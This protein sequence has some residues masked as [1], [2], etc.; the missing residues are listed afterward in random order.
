MDEMNSDES[1]TQR[2]FQAIDATLGHG[3]RGLTSPD[4]TLIRNSFINELKS[5]EPIDYPAMVEAVLGNYEPVDPSVKADRIKNIKTR[6]LTQPEKKKFDSQFNAVGS[7]INARIKRVY[8]LNDGI[9]LRVTRDIGDLSG[10]IQAVEENGFRY[11]RVKTN[12]DETFK[13]FRF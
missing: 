13:R 5:G 7:A 9:D 2:A 12:S 11:I 8:P 1:N 4:H 3:F 10:T 6:L